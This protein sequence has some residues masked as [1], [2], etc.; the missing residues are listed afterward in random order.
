MYNTIT[1]VFGVEVG[2][3]PFFYLGFIVDGLATY[4]IIGNDVGVAEVLE[5]PAVQ[6]QSS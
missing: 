6:R 5:C 2:V 4:L 1:S 3:E